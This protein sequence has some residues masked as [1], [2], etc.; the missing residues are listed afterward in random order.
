[1]HA[2][3]L[4]RLNDIVLCLCAGF[5]AS[6]GGGGL[7]LGRCLDMSRNTAIGPEGNRVQV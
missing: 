6:G 7:Q 1:M 4:I 3:R 2:W 5:R